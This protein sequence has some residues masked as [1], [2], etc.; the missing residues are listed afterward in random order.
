M[1][2]I[3]DAA[4]PWYLRLGDDRKAVL[5]AWVDRN[6]TDHRSVKSLRLVD[7]GIVEVVTLREVDGKWTGQ[8]DVR[9]VVVRTP[10]PWIAWG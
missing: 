4:D 7:E 10:P 1:R 9:Q 8:H 6:V 5:H 2:T 3:V